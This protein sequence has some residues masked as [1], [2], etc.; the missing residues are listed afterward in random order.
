MTPVLSTVFTLYDL[1]YDPDYSGGIN[2]YSITVGIIWRID[3]IIV[4]CGGSLN[5]NCLFYNA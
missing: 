1:A 4:C 3:V 5:L 2:G